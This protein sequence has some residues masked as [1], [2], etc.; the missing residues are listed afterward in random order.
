MVWSLQKT[1]S[2]TEKEFEQWR[3]LLEE[4][5]GILVTPK[6]QP[7][8]QTQITMRMRELG[9]TDYGE[10]YDKLT[11][12]IWGKAEWSVLVGCLRCFRRRL[13][14]PDALASGFPQFHR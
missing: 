2:F 1:E 13:P 14:K 3:E 6:Q 4:R 11:H 7:F 10:Y 9:F 12:G 8:M 5:T